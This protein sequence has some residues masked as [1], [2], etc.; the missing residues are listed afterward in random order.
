MKIETDLKAVAS[1]DLQ[2]QV[3]AELKLADPAPDRAEA[4]IKGATLDNS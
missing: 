3:E 1:E 2:T 4:A